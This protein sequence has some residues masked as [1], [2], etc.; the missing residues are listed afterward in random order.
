[1]NRPNQVLLSLVLAA[2]FGTFFGFAMWFHQEKPLI[3]AA[4]W[5]FSSSSYDVKM[6][7]AREL[8][9][10][11]KVLAD[12]HDLLAHT[13][14]T[15]NGPKGHLGLIPQATVL[16]QKAQPAMD[17]LTAA[18]KHLDEAIQHTDAAIGG[19]NALLASGTATMGEVQASL[20]RVNALIVA[21]QGQVS[22]PS[23][24]TAL[25]NLS[26]SAKAMADGMQQLAA[27]STD[28]RQIADKARETYLKPVN[29]WWGLVKELLPLAGSAA[30]VVK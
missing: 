13:D 4:L 2:L 16:V 12:A 7:S 14:I 8:Q 20:A 6:N 3:H 25:D 22:D 15:L 27:A 23:I 26:V 9:E 19:L 29:L 5:N 11:N 18:T 10:T 21:L 1:V 24:K 28:V 17:N 30:Q